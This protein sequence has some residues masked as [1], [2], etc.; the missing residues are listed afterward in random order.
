MAPTHPRLSEPAIQRKI[1]HC[2]CDCF[3]ASVEMRDDPSLRGRP[4]AVGGAADA[5]AA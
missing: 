1:I 2:D 5:G 3:Y 4:M